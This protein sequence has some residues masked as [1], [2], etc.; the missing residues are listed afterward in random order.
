MIAM[1]FNS[2]HTPFCATDSPLTKRWILALLLLIS[3]IVVFHSS[4]RLHGENIHEV[5]QHGTGDV[6]LSQKASI[7]GKKVA[8]IIENRALDNL[9]PL[10]L[11]FSTVLGPEWPIVLFTDPSLLQLPDFKSPAF[12]RLVNS[13]H[14]SI[15]PLGE[16]VH[17]ADSVAVS[18]FL[19]NPWVWEQLAPADHV[20]LFQS[21]SILCSKSLHTAD[22]FLM[23]DFIG[24]P[25]VAFWGQGFNGGLSLRNRNMMLDII[26]KS[27]FTAERE[28]LPEPISVEDQWF[29]KKMLELPNKADGSPGACFPTMEVAASFAVQSVWDESPL[30]YHQVTMWQSENLTAITKWCPEWRLLK[31]GFY[32]AEWGPMGGLSTP[33]THP[34]G[35]SG[36][37]SYLGKTPWVEVDTQWAP[38]KPSHVEYNVQNA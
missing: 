27:N 4:T 25:V 31:E 15:I 29:Y 24:A 1:S 18:T 21:D 23:Y 36:W 8:T 5:A 26:A 17:F 14:I 38:I 6:S 10:I 9:I 11:H 3:L 2:T 34:W 28:E 37:V 32:S 7:K 13:G 33:K 12:A 19:T 20:L 35:S 22:D 30:G 16:D